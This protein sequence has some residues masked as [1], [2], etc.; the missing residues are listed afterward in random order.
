ME[1]FGN[2]GAEVTIHKPT[3]STDVV[4][5]DSER[6][7]LLRTLNIDIGRKVVE[8]EIALASLDQCSHHEALAQELC[9]LSMTAQLSDKFPYSQVEIR[10]WTDE[11][12]V[13]SAVGLKGFR[14][15]DTDFSPDDTRWMF[16]HIAAVAI[17]GCLSTP[18]KD[19]A[20][21]VSFSSDKLE[22]LWPKLRYSIY[23]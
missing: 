13:Y 20:S 8:L 7:A 10:S 17:G 11:L 14:E 1:K 3:E 4:D 9:D 5:S 18:M 22:S 21:V 23:T 19:L 15:L 16:K 12:G 6:I 2:Y